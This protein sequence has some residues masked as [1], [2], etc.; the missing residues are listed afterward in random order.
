MRVITGYPTSFGV[1]GC[2]FLEKV[3]GTNEL[4]IAGKE[5]KK[6]LA[7]VNAAFIPHK[8]LMISDDLDQDFPLLKGKKAEEATRIFLCKDYTCLAPFFSIK[9]LLDNL[10]ADYP[11]KSRLETG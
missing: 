6:L 9:E 10:K 8:V 2:L 7:E 1:W 3:F 5:Y 4:V 11:E